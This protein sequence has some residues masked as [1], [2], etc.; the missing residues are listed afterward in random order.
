MIDLILTDSDLREMLRRL[1][2]HNGLNNTAIACAIHQSRDAITLAAEVK[3]LQTDNTVLRMTLKQTKETKKMAK[4]LK[5]KTLTDEEREL[6]LEAVEE[7]LI[8]YEQTVGQVTKTL[9]LRRIVD[10]IKGV[11]QSEDQ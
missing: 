2:V 1:R 8:E 5:F 3:R 9:Q 10:K 6:V 11:D 7:Y 4:P